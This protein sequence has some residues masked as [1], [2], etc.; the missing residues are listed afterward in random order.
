MFTITSVE[1]YHYLVEAIKN[2]LDD[3]NI[4][5]K[6]AKVAPKLFNSYEAKKKFLNSYIMNLLMNGGGG[7]RAFQFMPLFDFSDSVWILFEVFIISCGLTLVGYA[8]E[9]ASL[10]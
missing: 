4:K 5:T 9:S 2:F 8:C 7:G 3:H 6:G 1:Q 10:K